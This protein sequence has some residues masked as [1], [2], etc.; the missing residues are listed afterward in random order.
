M[1]IL[2]VGNT[3]AYGERFNGTD[4][5]KKLR[6]SGVKSQYCVWD[7]STNDKNVWQIADFKKRDDLNKKISSAEKKLSLQSLLYPWTFQLLFDKR[8]RKADLVHYHLIHSANFNIAALPLLSRMKPSVWTL[9]DP[10]AMTGHCIH[11]LGC[12]RWRTGCEKCPRID[13][14]IPMKDDRTRFMWKTKSFLFR[15]S[16]IDIIVASKWMLNLVK[17]SPLM[18]KLKVHLIPFGL[19]LK[20]FR[21]LNSQLSKKKLGISPDSFVIAFRA[22]NVEFKGLNFI[23]KVLRQLNSKR[24]I[25]LLTFNDKGLM[26]KFKDKYQIVDLGWIDDEK[27]L[28]T[29]YNAA[30]VFLMPSLAEAFGMMAIEAMACGKP[31]LTFKG[32]SLEEVIHAPEGGIAV[33]MGDTNGLKIE[34][35]RLL[36]RP[37]LVRQMGTKARKLAIKYYDEKTYLKRLMSLYKEVI[38]DR[39]K[40]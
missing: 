25:C 30:D 24:K 3:D 39:A 12:E 8:F 13:V 28:V 6:L 10:W 36:K 27:Y 23:K 22:I 38:R 21:P 40:N 17:S 7:K 11:P 20:T 26:D 1:K 2:Q 33:P 32:T 4:L 14:P 31:I 18:S 9:H 29:A 16:K 5:S 35:E 15:H 19:D 37:I 34:I